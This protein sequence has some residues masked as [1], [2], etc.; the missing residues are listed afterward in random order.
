MVPQ[1]YSKNNLNYAVLYV[2]K[3]YFPTP[4]TSPS[5]LYFEESLDCNGKVLKLW[6]LRLQKIWD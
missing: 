5:S 1:F 2:M 6:D 4:Q 3:V